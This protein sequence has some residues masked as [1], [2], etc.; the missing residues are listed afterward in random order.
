[1]LP[2]NFKLADYLQRIAYSGE[3]KADYAT[4]KQLMT[5]Q[6]QNV[7][8]ENLDV[9]AGKPISLDPQ[10]IVE[11]IVYRRR[12]GYC[13]ELNGLFAMALDSIGFA[14]RIVACRPMFYPARRP[15]THAALVVTAEG[16]EYL[17]DLGFGSYGI[18][19]PMDLAVLD[20]PVVQDYDRYQLTIAADGDYVLS[21]LVEGEW[22][23]QHGFNL[24]PMEWLDFMPANWFNSTHPDAVFTQKPL[25]LLFTPTGKRVL[26][27]DSFK[28]TEQGKTTV[29]TVLPKQQTDILAEYFHLK[30]S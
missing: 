14:Y 9:L 24:T 23:K 7:P 26:F 27:G 2:E 18:R 4:L 29:Q 3:V 1:M 13:Y 25:I 15:R 10:T 8:F 28:Q 5:C 6:L 12:G 19:Q 16:Q 21:A 30:F 20:T 22:I 17:V 11:K